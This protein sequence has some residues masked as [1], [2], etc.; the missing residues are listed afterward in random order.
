[1]N[2]ILKRASQKAQ[3]LGKKVAVAGSVLVGGAVQSQAAITASDVDMAGATGDITVVF[4]AMLGVGVL[5]FGYRKIN[6]ML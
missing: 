3:G 6:G 5:I 2:R 4:I 1:M